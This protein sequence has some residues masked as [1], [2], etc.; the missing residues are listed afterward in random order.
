MTNIDCQIGGRLGEISANAL[1]TA[2]QQTVGLL[3]E[4]DAALYGKGLPSLRWNVWDM[5]SDNGLLI[6]FGSEVPRRKRG[7][8]VSDI[9]GAIANGLIDGINIISSDSRVPP[10][11]SEYG[12]HR[13]EAMTR[14]IARNEA[15]SF[16]LR[17]NG[18]VA[19]VDS[20]TSAKLRKLSDIRRTSIGSVEGR[21]VGINVAK[22]PRVTIIH[23][24][25]NKSVSCPIEQGQLD[26]VKTSLGK[27]V[28]VS[29]VLHK[30][31]AGDTIR[32]N[33][34]SI[35]HLSRDLLRQQLADISALPIPDFAR[36]ADTEEYL[37]DIRG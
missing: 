28:I 12:F 16:T 33:M 14:I 34:R 19:S 11:M 4:Y 5:K 23:H 1:R 18:H 37:R 10:Y 6:R 25:S 30:N 9:S 20:E 3:D 2:V 7:P 31:E 22:N 27:K 8:V 35:H 26:L 29:G 36:Q 21:L 32:V 17:T 24:L 13:L 15:Q